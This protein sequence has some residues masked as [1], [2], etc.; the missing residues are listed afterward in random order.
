MWK[1][2]LPKNCPPENAFEMEQTVFRLLIGEQQQEKDFYSYVRLFPENS[3]YKNMCK[4]YSLSTFNTKENAIN[5]KKK[6]KR[7]DIGNYVCEM[8]ITNEVGKNVFSEKTGHFSTW[9]YSSWEYSNFA[10]N[11]IE[12]IDED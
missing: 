11:N 1:E 3:R 2:E 8:Q 9:I 10:I 7:N 12:Q 4:A 6:S 5:A